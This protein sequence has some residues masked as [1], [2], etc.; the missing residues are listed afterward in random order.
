[1]PD[2]DRTPDAGGSGAGKTPA[3]A[4]RKTPAVRSPKTA[5][6]QGT[7]IDQ[8]VQDPADVPALGTLV[9]FAG[10][11]GEPGK[12]RIHSDA[13]LSRHVEVDEDKVRHVEELDAAVDEVLARGHPW[14]CAIAGHEAPGLMLGLAGIGLFHL[15]IHR[16]GTPRALHLRAGRAWRAPDA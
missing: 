6:R 16:P 11:A 15:R 14:P 13:S 7:F 3:A 10:K 9:G 1:M 12:V 2:D 8:L 4:S 5:A